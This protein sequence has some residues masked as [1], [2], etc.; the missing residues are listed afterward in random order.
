MSV[1]DTIIYIHRSGPLNRRNKRDLGAKKPPFTS[2]KDQ[3][4]DEKIHEKAMLG[5]N[6]SHGVM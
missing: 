5:D 4:Y 3:N 1:G 2:L 6:K